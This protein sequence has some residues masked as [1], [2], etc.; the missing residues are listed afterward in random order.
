LGYNVFSVY[1]EVRGMKDEDI[2]GKAY[3]EDFIII[4]N[5]K[6]FGELIYRKNLPHKGIVL[7][8]L[9]D[10]HSQ[11]KIKVITELLANYED[12]LSEHFTVVT[13]K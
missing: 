1:D 13:E 6:D 9:N 7:L 12:K 8:R 4:T 5:D 10:G 2:L 11:N 3:K